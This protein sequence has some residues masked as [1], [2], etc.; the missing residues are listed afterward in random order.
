[1]AGRK[2][3]GLCA[4]SSVAVGVAAILVPALV[5]G[6]ADE[7]VSKL[8]APRRSTTSTLVASVTMDSTA[9]VAVGATVQLHAT[10][11]GV[12]GQV[13]EPS[14]VWETSNK[15]IATVDSTGVVKGVTA[16]AATIYA[17]SGTAWAKCTV[18]VTTAT[19]TVASIVVSPTTL[20]LLAGQ[21]G[22]LTAVA[23]DSVGSPLS[24][25]ISWATSAPSVATVSPGGLVTG[26]VAGSAT[27]TAS[28]GGKSGSASV[29]VT[30][31]S[32]SGSVASV[33]VSPASLSLTPGQTGQLS[34]VVKDAAGNT[35]SGQTVSWSSSAPGV[36]TVLASGLVTAVAA[37]QATITGSAGGV[38][39]TASVTVTSS[40]GGFAITNDFESG[41]PSPY[42]YPWT[43]SPT[44]FQIVSDPTATGHGQVAQLHYHRSSSDSPDCNRALIWHP[45]T[46]IGFGQTFY[47][48]G[49]FYIP[50][51]TSTMAN[52]NRKLTYWLK[53]PSSSYPDYVVV[54]AWGNGLY[55]SGGTYNNPVNVAGI[56]TVNFNQWYRLEIQTTINSGAT[57]SDGAIR[58]WLNGT[59]VYQN[60]A[61]AFM[62]HAGPS[63]NFTDMGF[64]YQVNASLLYDE[65]RYWDSVSFSSYRLP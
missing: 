14:F 48:R 36:A 15:S 12:D 13:L 57:T 40:S 46:P 65:Y 5:A 1:M 63:E 35:L 38:T 23:K 52:Q 56:A 29:A 31:L 32:S 28:A 54:G 60:S 51:P 61:I 10:A 19:P 64:G 20:N 8:A 21:T 2:A 62:Q 9:T 26:L 53:N 17:S 58:V 50:Q 18:T 45:T 42:I 22:Q 7:A 25:A 44:D 47:F 33:V 3:R 6:C 59:L 55:F 37:G 24:V 41:S 27:I 16:G 39:G 43:G 30:S 34:A 11:Y 49:S 4:P